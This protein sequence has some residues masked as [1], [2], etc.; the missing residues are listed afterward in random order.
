MESP[1]LRDFL[2]DYLERILADNV[3]ARR[4]LPDGSYVPAGDGQGEPVNVQQYYLDHPPGADADQGTQA[5]RRGMAAASAPPHIR[6][7]PDGGAAPFRPAWSIPGSQKTGKFGL[8]KRR[9]VL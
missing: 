1:E 4:L 6:P 3:K 7:M 2:W 5:R 8:D 9:E